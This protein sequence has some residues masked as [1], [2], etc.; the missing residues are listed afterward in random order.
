MK[1]LL[2]ASIT[3]AAFGV[4]MAVPSIAAAIQLTAPTST[5]VAP[6]TNLVATNVAHAETAKQSLLTS[7]TEVASHVTSPH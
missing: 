7:E 6:G 2:R 5:T 4:L 1:Y 3:M